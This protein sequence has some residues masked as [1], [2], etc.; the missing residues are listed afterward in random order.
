M[1]PVP[2]VHSVRSASDGVAYC[3]LAVKSAVNLY[4]FEVAAGALT[5]EPSVPAEGI[6]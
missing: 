3:A 4:I 2:V 1:F 5:I 6:V